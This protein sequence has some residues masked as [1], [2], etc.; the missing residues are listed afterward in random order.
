MLSRS[1]VHIDGEGKTE[2]LVSMNQGESMTPSEFLSFAGAVERLL[3]ETYSIDVQGL[4]R[5]D[6]PAH[7]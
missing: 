7:I 4:D 5:Q 6:S 1:I 2:L 3:M